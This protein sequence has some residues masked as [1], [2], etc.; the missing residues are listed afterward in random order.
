MTV[1]DKVNNQPVRLSGVHVIMSNRNS[2]GLENLYV[3]HLVLYHEVN[4]YMH[5]GEKHNKDTRICM[6][7][8]MFINTCMISSTF[9]LG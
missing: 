2:S 1:N 9:D 4:N 6:Y 7:H 3:N 8:P 5:I